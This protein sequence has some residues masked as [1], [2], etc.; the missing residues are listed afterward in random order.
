MALEH[1]SSGQP[2]QVS[3]LGLLCFLPDAYEAEA[4]R[5]G[6]FGSVQWIAVSRDDESFVA[7]L[8]EVVSV[9]Q[10]TEPPTPNPS[11]PWCALRDGLGE[12]V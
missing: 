9:L 1:P 2:E 10:A 12:A 5:A 7:F 8:G 3:S 6:L 4:G 11:C